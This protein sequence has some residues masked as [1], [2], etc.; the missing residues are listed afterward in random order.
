MCRLW[1]SSKRKNKR[2]RVGRASTINK[3][4]S[5][6]K[7]LAIG[8]CVRKLKGERVA[9]NKGAETG[10]H[11]DDTKKKGSVGASGSGAQRGGRNRKEVGVRYVERS[12]RPKIGSKIKYLAGRPQ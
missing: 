5:P 9:S 6:G 1:P 8:K 3:Q 7:K 12:D 10:A 2:N 4:E 11:N